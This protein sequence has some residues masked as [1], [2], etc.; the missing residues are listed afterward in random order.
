MS[1]PLANLKK[2]D[3]LQRE[4][5]TSEMVLWPRFL[6]SEAPL[7]CCYRRSRL[8]ARQKSDLLM[9]PSKCAHITS[10]KAHF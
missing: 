8:S 9:R 1:E 7:F 6:T 2:E 3:A 10:L 5:V 4:S